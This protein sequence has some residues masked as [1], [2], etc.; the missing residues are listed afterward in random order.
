MDNENFTIKEEVVDLEDLILPPTEQE[1][2]FNDSNT[3]DANS[4][5]TV[6][7]K[8]H[9]FK[10][11]FCESV[12]EGIKPY[13]CKICYFET[14]EKKAINKH[15]ESIHEGIKAFNCNICGF[16]TAWNS[17]L[18]RHT[19]S[20][21]E[22]IKRFKCNICDFKTNQNSNLNRHKESVHEGIKPFKCNI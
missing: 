12:H 1:N 10:E 16:K 6:S 9:R 20:V 11:L 15:I 19:D 18:K 13:K 8:S 7:G 5:E 22:G 3:E 4:F 2:K 21:H 17:D 14:A